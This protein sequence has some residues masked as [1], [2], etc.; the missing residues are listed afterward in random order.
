MTTRPKT[1]Y[2]QCSLTDIPAAVSWQRPYVPD[3]S[4]LELEYGS[5]ARQPRYEH[6]ALYRRTRQPGGEWSYS[7]RHTVVPAGAVLVYAAYSGAARVPGADSPRLTVADVL[8][9][10][11]ERNPYTTSGYEWELHW[12]DDDSAV[13]DWEL[14]LFSTAHHETHEAKYAAC[15]ESDLPRR[16]EWAPSDEVYDYAS[17]RSYRRRVVVDATNTPRWSYERQLMAVAS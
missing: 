9:A 15:T 5:T 8:R 4:G 1:T 13:E 7:R 3:T 2:A 17:D 10:E 6:G 16:L 12:A 14:G 11:S